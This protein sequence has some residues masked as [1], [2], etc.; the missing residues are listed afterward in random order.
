[1]EVVVKEQYKVGGYLY[2][3]K[4]LAERLDALLTQH[5]DSK[6]CPDCKGTR[7]V[8]YLTTETVADEN[9]YISGSRGVQKE[10]TCTKCKNGILIKVISENWV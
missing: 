3:D 4:A 7:I 8:T 9:G 5:P 1:M 6:I 2:D 10:R